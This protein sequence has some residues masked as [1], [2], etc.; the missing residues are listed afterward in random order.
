MKR[1]MVMMLGEI[2]VRPNKWYSLS[3]KTKND[4][5]IGDVSI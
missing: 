3:L 4:V 5:C 1:V 2:R